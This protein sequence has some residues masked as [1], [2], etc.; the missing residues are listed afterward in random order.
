MIA[1]KKDA[2]SLEFVPDRIINYEICLAA[3]VESEIKYVN[4]L[5]HVPAY[6]MTSEL[7]ESAVKNHGL[8]LQHVP[9][10]LKTSEL[11]ELA[12][13]NHGTALEYVP[14]NFKTSKLCELAVINNIKA[15]RFVDDKETKNDLSYKY[16][17][18][19]DSIEK[20]H[21]DSVHKPPPTSYHKAPPVSGQVKKSLAR[22]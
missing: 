12:V 1:V 10:Y 5:I 6:I 19:Q 4:I 18:T 7:C 11:C 16:N 2:K 13:Q 17:I 15:I 9:T 3:I 21:Y 22:R 14:I 20:A 8:A